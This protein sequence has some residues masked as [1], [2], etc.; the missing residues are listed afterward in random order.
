MTVRKSKQLISAEKKWLNKRV[1]YY[2]P[3]LNR[4]GSMDG[5]YTGIVNGVSTNESIIEDRLEN[6]DG[7]TRASFTGTLIV[8]PDD[9]AMT[10]DWAPYLYA[11]I[12][13]D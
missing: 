12:I 10:E 5:P 7:R 6:T 9:K 4:D 1:E 11:T 8:L 3:T 13:E 2:L